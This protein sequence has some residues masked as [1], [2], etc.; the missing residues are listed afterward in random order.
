MTKQI[1][2][3][4]AVVVDDGRVLC[5]R[6][7][8][9]GPLAGLWEFPGG[10]VESGETVKEALVREIAEELDCEVSVGE[11]VADTTHEYGFGVV[12]LQTYFCRLSQGTPRPSE[13][14]ELQ[15]L[16]PEQLLELAWAPA[17]IPAVHIVQRACER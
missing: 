7:G 3:V 17:D 15:W 6:R 16:E 4:A 14:S 11:G 8:P 2:V 9:G 5:A 12:R 13:H 1:H 10:K